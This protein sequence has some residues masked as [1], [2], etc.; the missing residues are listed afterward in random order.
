M[1]KIKVLFLDRD[2]VIN[3]EVNYLHQISE[4]KFINGVFDS[5]R[6][7]SSY[8]FKFIIVSNQSGIG[9]GMYGLN[10]F[11]VL[12]KWML[13]KFKKN[14]IEILDV[15]ICPHTDSDNCQ[16]RKPKDGL[17]RQAY[18]KYCIDIDQSW[19]IGD[20]ER[21]IEASLSAGILNNIL[22]RSGH[23]ISESTT[24]ASVIIDSI[25]DITKVIKS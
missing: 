14:R 15:F 4:F 16:C 23:T 7:L 24:K 2:G 21:D 13:D 8:G 18:K 20:S 9:R 17:F 12:N 11:K 10:E 6:D 1:K 19:M 5:L 25:K 3:E 22:V